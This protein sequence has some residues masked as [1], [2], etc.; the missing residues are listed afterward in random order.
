LTYNEMTK[1]QLIT[2]L[3][4]WIETLG[5]PIGEGGERIE[6]GPGDMAEMMAIALEIRQRIEARGMFV[7]WAILDCFSTRF[8]PGKEDADA[9]GIDTT[10]ASD[11][12]A[13]YRKLIGVLAF[14]LLRFGET[15]TDGSVVFEAAP[16]SLWRVD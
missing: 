10:T 3:R 14:M 7:D 5:K 4:H 12:V 11:I 8:A 15:A 9:T 1:F 2:S 13:L 6:L 16:E